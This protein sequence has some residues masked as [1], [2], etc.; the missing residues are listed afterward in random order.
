MPDTYESIRAVVDLGIESKRIQKSRYH[1]VES[2]YAV[3]LDMTL[4]SSVRTMT[5]AQLN[6]GTIAEIENAYIV[7][8]KLYVEGEDLSNL[9]WLRDTGYTNVI[10]KNLFG[11]KE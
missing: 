11:K 7:E 2:N 5:A 8:G 3:Q 4:M 1:L 6:K 9:L 10:V